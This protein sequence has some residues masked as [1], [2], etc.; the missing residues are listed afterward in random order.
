[1]RILFLHGALNGLSSEYKVHVNLVSN[2]DRSEIEPYFVWQ[3]SLERVKPQ[4]MVQENIAQVR[5]EQVVFL[6]FG[7]NMSIT[8]K[9]SRY[10]RAGMMIQRLPGA[11]RSLILKVNQLNPDLIYTS[12]QYFDVFIARILCYFSHI[13]HVI[14]LHYSVGPWLGSSVL[15]TIRNSSRLIAVSEFVR[16]T[17][18]LQGV[19]SSH[20]H[21]VINAAPL[22]GVRRNV[23][24]WD[25]RN[26]F[27][28]EH[29]TPL[30][31]AVG[32]LDPGKGHLPLFEAF[33]RVVKCMPEAQLLVCGASTTRDNFESRLR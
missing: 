17:A 12:Q 21:T 24:R 7:R 26:G 18:L 32:R 20:I 33:A 29:N 3:S 6:D 9:P 16:Q 8:P 2:V 5:P 27:E 22:T 14:H 13:P 1:V 4:C 15:K 25:I 31:L 28:I 30:I 11:L 23:D 10:T 19:P